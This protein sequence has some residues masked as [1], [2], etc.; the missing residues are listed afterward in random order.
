[1]SDAKLPTKWVVIGPG[2]PGDIYGPFETEATAQTWAVGKW[3][4]KHGLDVRPV[5]P[6]TSAP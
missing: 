6:P 4:G 5:F 2:T 3:P 1:M